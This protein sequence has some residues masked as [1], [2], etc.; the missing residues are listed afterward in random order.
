M[1]PTIHPQYY[2]IVISPSP[3]VMD[4]AIALSEK[5]FQYGA[6]WKLGRDHYIPHLSLY[7]IPVLPSLLENVSREL[8][9]IAGAQEPQILHTTDIE[10]V[11]HNGLQ[12]MVQKIPWLVQLHEKVLERLL[13][14]YDWAYEQREGKKLWSDLV[15]FSP[16]GMELFKKYGTPLAEEAFRPHISLARVANPEMREAILRDLPLKRFDFSANRLVVYELGENHT[17]QRKIAEFPFGQGYVKPDSS[18][19]ETLDKK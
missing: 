12:L 16:K 19:T 10:L 1:K 5:I 4:Y 18:P 7:H 15:R 9:L 8:K 17:C 6:P 11:G 3:E 2:D 13:P 14:H